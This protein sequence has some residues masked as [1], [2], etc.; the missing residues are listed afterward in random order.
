M[1]TE[2]RDLMARARASLKG[3]WGIAIGI[4]VAYLL[5]S[6][7]AGSPKYLKAL[8]FV[9]SG[10]LTVGYYT[11]F[12][13]IVRG[14]EVRFGQL[15][16][17]FRDFLNSFGAMLLMTVFIVLWS[18]LLI[19]PGIVDNPD[20]DAFKA[21]AASKEMMRGN[22]SKLFRLC[23]RFIGWFLAGIL[24]AGIGFI[25]IVPYASASLAHFY[26][27]LLDNSRKNPLA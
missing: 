27:D 7:I 11:A 25:W 18:L 26:Q 10:P 23:C 4:S 13:S 24:T 19:V 16:E 9:L 14:T 1:L 15:F 6:A 21:L 22:K 3:K 17:G 20:T 8:G 12:L 2:N 5:I